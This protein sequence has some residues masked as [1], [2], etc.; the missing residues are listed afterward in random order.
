MTIRWSRRERVVLDSQL[1]VLLC[2][3]L[4][5]RKKVTRH[6]RLSAYD[7][8]DFDLL[9]ALLGLCAEIVVSPNIATE[10]S[11]LLRSGSQDIRLQ[12][13]LRTFVEQ[14]AEIYVESRAAVSHPAYVRL[15]VSDASILHLLGQY[16]DTWLLTADLD[17]YLAAESLGLKV[18]NFNHVRNLRPDF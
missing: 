15:G 10:T 8:T 1:A 4:A 3:G 5:D 2:V 18:E 13:A 17:L 16:S 12:I 6:K 11:N 9:S 7:T 14:S